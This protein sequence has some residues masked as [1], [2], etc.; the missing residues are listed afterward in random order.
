MDFETNLLGNIGSHDLFEVGV[1][2]CTAFD[3]NSHLG[4]PVFS[5]KENGA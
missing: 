1:I 5:K 3:R 2:Y 4:N